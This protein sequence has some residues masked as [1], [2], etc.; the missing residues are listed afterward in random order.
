MT[1]ICGA[2]VVDYAYTLSHYKSKR[3][4][5]WNVLLLPLSQA[6][7][8]ERNMQQDRWNDQQQLLVTTHER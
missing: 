4:C 3:V 1:F 7:V 6:L 8:Q 2:S 5:L